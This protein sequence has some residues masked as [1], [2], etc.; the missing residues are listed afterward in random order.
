[1]IGGFIGPLLCGM[2]AR[3]LMDQKWADR[4][5]GLVLLLLGIIVWKYL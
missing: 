4:G 5:L 3:F 2:G 1:M